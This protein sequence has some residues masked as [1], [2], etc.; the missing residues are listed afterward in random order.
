MED[1]QTTEEHVGGAFDPHHPMFDLFNLLTDAVEV[2]IQMVKTVLQNCYL[3]LDVDFG[4]LK[5]FSLPEN[6]QSQNRFCR[7]VIGWFATVRP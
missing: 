3:D 5:H 1:N 7:A 2:I 4:W 6:Q